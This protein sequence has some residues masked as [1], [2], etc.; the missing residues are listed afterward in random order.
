MLVRACQFVLLM[1]EEKAVTWLTVSVLIIIDCLI[2]KATEHYGYGDGNKELSIDE[3][4]MPNQA[5]NER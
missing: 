2:E 5:S 3:R 1:G 4:M